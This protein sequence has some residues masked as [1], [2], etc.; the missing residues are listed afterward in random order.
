MQTAKFC[1]GKYEDTR[2]NYIGDFAKFPELPWL[3]KH[4]VIPPTTLG[5]ALRLIGG[6]PLFAWGFCLSTMLLWH[7]TF[8]INSLPHL[9]GTRRYETIHQQ[10]QLAPRNP[11]HSAKAGMTIITTSCSVRQGFF[12]WEIDITYYVLKVLS[13]T[14][15]VW[16]LPQSLHTH[17]RARA[18]NR[19]MMVYP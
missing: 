1:A 11:Q 16:D 4:H 12:W 10:E 18:A 9:F 2:L 14:D 3:N 5:V 8:T 19:C 6:W 15:L 13:W 7:D 17:A